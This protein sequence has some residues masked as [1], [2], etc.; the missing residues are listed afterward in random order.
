MW[1]SSV[2]E[3]CGFWRW[4]WRKLEWLKKVSIVGWKGRLRGWADIVRVLCWAID[5]LML[6][7]M[8]KLRGA[9]GWIRLGGG[10]AGSESQWLW[11]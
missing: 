9:D 10:G 11:G 2:A 6:A 1:G 5:R 8:G 3:E 7:V 4:G